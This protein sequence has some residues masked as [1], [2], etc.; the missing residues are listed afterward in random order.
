M[1]EQEQR[2][3]IKKERVANQFAMDILMHKKLIL[4]ALEHVK[5]TE[6][7]SHKYETKEKIRRH[8]I[9]DIAE[10]MKVSEILLTHRIEQLDID[11][12]KED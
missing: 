1:N 3:Y 10:I 11:I 7:P 5:K 12:L 8:R 2:D 9:A 4:L 6:H